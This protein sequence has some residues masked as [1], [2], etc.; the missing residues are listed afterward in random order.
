M[1]H[2]CWI[3]SEACP[4]LCGARAVSVWQG[5]GIA[6]HGLNILIMT[7]VSWPRA[8]QCCWQWEL[9]AA[10]WK[11]KLRWRLWAF[12]PQARGNHCSLEKISAQHVSFFFLIL[13]FQFFFLE[14][15]VSLEKNVLFLILGVLLS[16]H[17][18]F[19]SWVSG[20][21]HPHCHT[22]RSGV[23]GGLCLRAADGCAALPS[24]HCQPRSARNPGWKG[25]Q[26]WRA[27]PLKK[28]FL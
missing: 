19:V 16:V 23:P 12:H 9:W 15:A 22:V 18:G 1:L 3:P 10:A 14:C 20:Q 4:A 25:I 8:W 26:L 11:R 13:F 24:Q 2:R 6:L 21:T 7:S 27:K 17:L 5:R 28:K